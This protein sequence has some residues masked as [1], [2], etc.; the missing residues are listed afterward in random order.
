LA[1]PLGD[2]FVIQYCD[3]SE[4]TFICG[5]PVRVRLP[6]A[7]EDCNSLTISIPLDTSNEDRALTHAYKRASHASRY[8]VDYED[9]N[10]FPIAKT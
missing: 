9:E 10:F 4:L 3:K 7:F 2:I 1:A 5:I 8:L 6:A